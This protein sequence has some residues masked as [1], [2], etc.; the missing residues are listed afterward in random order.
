MTPVLR[1][2]WPMMRHQCVEVRGRVVHLTK[3]ETAVLS[4]L[5]CRR[6]QVVPREHIIEAIWPNPD[7]EIDWSYNWVNKYIKFLRDKIGKDMIITCHGRGVYV[8]TEEE[9]MEGIA[10]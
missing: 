1:M 9:F 4:T 10:A 6:G 2:T 7:D 8:P 3:A 5:L